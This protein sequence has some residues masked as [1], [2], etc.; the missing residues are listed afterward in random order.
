MDFTQEH[1][2]EIENKIVETIA[3]EVEK[4]NLKEENLKDIADFV[5]GRIDQ[6]KNQDELIAFL[7]ELSTK[8]TVF[9]TIE[10]MERANLKGKVEKEVAEGVLM[11]AKN[12]KIDEALNLAKTMTKT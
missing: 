3:D 5:L 12:G 1:K 4:G 2:T 7:F 6:I 11:L 9:K 8:W 10:T